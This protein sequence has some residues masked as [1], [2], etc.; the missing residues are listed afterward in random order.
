MF[1]TMVLHGPGMPVE[2]CN[3][4]L[5]S[6][7]QLVI[8][9]LSIGVQRVLDCR[10]SKDVGHTDAAEFTE[11]TA[12]LHCRQHPTKRTCTFVSQKHLSVNST[13]GDINIIVAQ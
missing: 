9:R 7:N 8:Q 2:L 13:T 11:H 12:Q 10:D 6:G 1:V 4:P 5:S 3:K